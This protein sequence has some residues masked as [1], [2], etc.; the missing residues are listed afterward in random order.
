MKTT[1]LM[2]INE[3]EYGEHPMRTNPRIGNCNAC[4][5]DCNLSL[6]AGTL[7]RIRHRGLAGLGKTCRR[8]ASSVV[9]ATAFF[10]AP[11]QAQIVFDA[12]ADFSITNGNPNEAWSYGWMPTDFSVFNL[13]TTT[14]TVGGGFPAWT[15]LDPHASG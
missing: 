5:F 7:P 12:T 6:L 13:C 10:A 8:L 15:S 14:T 4:G 2:G 11:L 1:S 3:L 9:L